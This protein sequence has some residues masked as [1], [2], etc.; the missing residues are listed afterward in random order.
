[1]D[2]NKSV[3]ANFDQSDITVTDTI[4]PVDDLQLPFGEVT[5]GNF[6]QATVT[7]TNNGNANLLIGNIASS[8]P[9]VAPFSIESNDCSGGAVLP[10]ASCTLTIR[11]APTTAG[12]FNGSFDIPSDDPDED[13]VIVN[14]SGTG[15]Q[16]TDGDGIQNGEDN[17]PNTPNSG[18]EDSDEDGTGNVC[19]NCPDDPNKGEPGICGCGISDTDSNGDGTPDCTDNCPDDPNKT[20][21]GICGCGFSDIDSDGNGTPDCTDDCPDDPNKTEP[22]ICGCGASDTDSDGDGTPDCT[23]NCPDDPN[24]TEPG[25]CG[26]GISDTDSDNDQI[27]D[28]NDAFPDDPNEW[29]DTDEDGVGNNTDPDDDSDELPDDWEIA[30][31]LDPLDSSEDNGRD[32]DLDGDSW[33]NYDEYVYGTHPNDG[34]IVPIRPEVVDV[35]PHDGAGIGD[36]DTRVPNNISFAALI[37]DSNGIDITDTDS[38]WFTIDDSKDVYEINLDVTQDYFVRITKLDPNEDNKAVTQL[39]AVYHR[40]EDSARG[41]TYPFDTQI[42][43]TVYA[44]DSTGFPMVQQGFSFKIETEAQ[45]LYAQANSPE[46][47]PVAGDDPALDD[48][49]HDTG[50]KVTS[51]DLQGAKIFYHIDEPVSPALGPTNELPRLDVTNTDA[52]GTPMNLQ[53]PTVFAIPVKVFI[54]CPGHTDVSSLNVYLYKGTSWVLACD[55]A[56]N[57][58]PGI[59]SWMV[60]GS[61]LDHNNGAPSTIEIRIYHFSGVQAGSGNQPPTARL[62]A[63]P[64]SGE[65]QL[66]VR[67][68][69]SSSWDPDGHIMSYDWIFGDGSTGSSVSPF[70]VYTSAGTYTVK[71]TVTDDEGVIDTATGKITV[72]S[73]AQNE[74]PKANFL[75]DPNS[76][77]APLTVSFDA[78]GS[79]DPDGTIVSFMWDFGDGVTSTRQV[80][81]NQYTSEG[82]Y[83]VTLTVTDND[84]S[85][86]T[87]TSMITVTA[88]GSAGDGGGGGGCFITA[89][90]PSLPTIVNLIGIIH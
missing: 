49:E 84:G 2:G 37:K 1:M 40:A 51:G 29:L 34:T 8:D 59:E 13:P 39:W 14:V 15:T 65:A 60:P 69:A 11:F 85:K 46:T 81:S 77:A 72:T 41:N 20:Q 58:Q 66:F 89:E 24:K 76:G 90:D 63:N 19:D 22:G 70:H 3:L 78:T 18:Q 38:T 75:S 88:S 28:C 44:K 53:P 23:D 27:L 68:D 45:H 55:A 32:G 47:V 30:S 61:R 83:S 36:D 25:I 31:G 87:T 16:D 12:T 7:V 48:P 54:P 79:K 26:C 67:F 86:N 21:P 64:T 80:T 42:N 4:A 9:L 82:I 6:S 10:V 50:I 5:E 57:V 33:S 62:T 17:C 71:L 74:D 73:E 52:V 56:G 43:I 35:I